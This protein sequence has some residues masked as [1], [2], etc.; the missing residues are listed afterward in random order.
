MNLAHS[1]NRKKVN[2]GTA[3]MRSVNKRNT[4]AYETTQRFSLR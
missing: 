2:M 4:G 1:R 3:K